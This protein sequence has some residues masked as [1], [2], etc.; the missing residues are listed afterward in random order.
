VACASGAVAFSLQLVISHPLD[1]VKT[2][3][4]SEYKPQLSGFGILQRTIQK[5]GLLGLYAGMVPAGLM[6]APTMAARYSLYRILLAYQLDNDDRR[7]TFLE[8]FIAGS[9]AALYLGPLVSFGELIKVRRQATPNL[10]NNRPTF[11]NEMKGI[12]ENEGFGALFRGNY[13]TMG[14][15]MLTF[16]LFYAIYA[17]LPALRWSA[18]KEQYID[19]PEKPSLSM[20]DGSY[21]ALSLA[22]HVFKGS[23]LFGTIAVILHPIDALKTRV[24][25]RII[26]GKGTVTKQIILSSSACANSLFTF[27]YR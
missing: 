21:P 15:E 12:R 27:V 5:R 16:G 8:H 18:I 25:N 26:P 24:Q 14:R 11:V 3:L 20:V 17:Q 13:I 2:L 4:Q 22:E 10:F 7:A 1:T 19:L 6:Q 23:L 9:S